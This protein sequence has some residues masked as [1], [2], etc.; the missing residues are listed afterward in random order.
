MLNLRIG[1]KKDNIEAP[2][3]DVGDFDGQQ[4]RARRDH[5]SSPRQRMYPDNVANEDKDEGQRASTNSL[6]RDHQR[7]E[8]NHVSNAQS[9]GLADQPR[10][11]AIMHPR[12]GAREGQQR[13]SNSKQDYIQNQLVFALSDFESSIIWS[14]D[15][16][17]TLIVKVNADSVLILQDQI[18]TIRNGQKQKDKGRMRL[19]GAA[20]GRSTAR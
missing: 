10:R 18:N 20:T 19:D 7:R 11:G 3:G 9:R 4:P 17:N 1:G 8:L 6:N 16:D 5:I 12:Q 13:Y 15:K 2:S 14:E